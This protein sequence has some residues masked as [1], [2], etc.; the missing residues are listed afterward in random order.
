MAGVTGSM[1]ELTREG[2]AL[3]FSPTIRGFNPVYYDVLKY[4]V[5]TIET[6]GNRIA[7]PC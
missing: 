6:P 5:I 2:A 1:R 4:S 3:D 7:D